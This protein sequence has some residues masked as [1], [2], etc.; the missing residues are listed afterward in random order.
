MAARWQPPLELPREAR[1]ICDEGAVQHR[2]A[3][4]PV[5]AA[6]PDRQLEPFLPHGRLVD[7]A[8]AALGRRAGEGGC[9]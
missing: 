7:E 9:T 5:G 8:C 3:L 6:L 4:G 1:L 2:R